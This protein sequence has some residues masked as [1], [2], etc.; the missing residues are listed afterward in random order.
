VECTDS[1]AVATFFVAEPLVVGGKAGL[2]C[3]LRRLAL[4]GLRRRSPEGVLG[5]GIA[6][7]RVLD[8]V[9]LMLGQ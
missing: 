5:G 3:S 8:L 4:V 9:D 2:H 6:G 1:T 7:K